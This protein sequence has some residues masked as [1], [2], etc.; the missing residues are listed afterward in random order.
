MKRNLDGVFFR[1]K[2][3]EKWQPIC[4]S[5]LTPSERDMLFEDKERPAEFWKSIAYHLA[6]RLQVIGDEFD[7]IGG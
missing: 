2:R 1:V 4:F 5:D 6:D 7:I 3:E